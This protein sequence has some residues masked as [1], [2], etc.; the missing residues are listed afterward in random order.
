MIQ[1]SIFCRVT[2]SLVPVLI[3][4]GFGYADQNVRYTYKC[5]EGSMTVLVNL[6]QTIHVTKKNLKGLFTA[7]QAEAPT[8]AG[9]VDY[10]G[11]LVSLTTRRHHG[12]HLSVTPSFLNGKSPA[13]IRLD[14]VE[15][16]D[17]KRD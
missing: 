12:S 5:A 10:R 7:G 2:F 16:D 6:D 9:Y 4:C 14:R 13:T 8:Q 3:L 1:T 17:C 11:K 15:Y